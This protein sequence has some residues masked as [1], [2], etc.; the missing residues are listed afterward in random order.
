MKKHRRIHLHEGGLF[1]DL[2]QPS[3]SNPL[4]ALASPVDSSQ[5]VPALGAPV[6]ET[7]VIVEDS[8]D[9]HIS[10]GALKERPKKQTS[11]I[12]LLR[13][14]KP[15]PTETRPDLLTEDIERLNGKLEAA[16]AKAASSKA[17]KAESVKAARAE[18]AH[19][20]QERLRLQERA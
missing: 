9:E 15:I 11:V 13:S 2:D 18:A 4:L 16:K 6:A 19:I 8:A 10:L 7:Q 1:D 12:D 5:P 3:G 17:A 14:P 20:G